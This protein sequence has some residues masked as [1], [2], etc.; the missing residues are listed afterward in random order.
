MKS[1]YLRQDLMRIVAAQT[2][3]RV[4][5]KALLSRVSPV[6]LDESLPD[7]PLPGDRWVRVRNIQTGICGSDMTL[8]SCTADAWNLFE[9]LNARPRVFLGHETVGVVE[10]TGAAVRGLKPGDR[11]ALQRYT[12]SCASKEIEPPCRFCRE[13]NYALCEHYN[14]PGPKELPD[15]GAGMGDRYLATEAQLYPVDA[16]LSDDRAV[17]LEPMAVA[18]HSVLRRPPRPGET[19]LVY[20][21]GAVGLLV[22]AVLKMLYPDCRIL[23][24]VRGQKKQALATRFGGDEVF[25]GDVYERVASLTGGRLYPGMKGRTMMGGG[26]DVIYDTLGRGKNT[27]DCLRLL[28]ARGSYVKIGYQ[29]NRTKYDETPLWFKEIEMIGVSSHG[30]ETVAE[31]SFSSFQLAEELLLSPKCP[32]VE[33]L[34]THRFPLDRYKEAFGLLLTPGSGAIKVVL[35]CAGGEA[36]G[37]GQ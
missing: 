16:A 37:Q 33:E 22:V 19:V 3:S 12:P 5:K 10:E 20:G 24:P 7:P 11:V 29:M 36:P 30:M 25:T 26:V 18:V 32:P 14:D 8:F 1:L 21:T 31:H 27:H 23:V 6:V 15:T 9:P 4:T 13:G 2:L 28:R 17:L 34:I 35:D